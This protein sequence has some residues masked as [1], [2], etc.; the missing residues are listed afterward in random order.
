[1]N[2]KNL[3]LQQGMDLIGGHT[4]THFKLY[5]DYKERLRSFGE[6]TDANVQKYIHGM[7]CWVAGEIHYAFSIP[8]YFGKDVDILKKNCLVDLL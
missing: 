8:K 1:M 7:D 5:N 2:E 6:A 3:T 4:E